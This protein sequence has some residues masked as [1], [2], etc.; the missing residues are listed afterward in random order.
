MKPE[1]IELFDAYLDGVMSPDQ[2]KDMEQ[3]ILTEPGLKE[4]LELH[5]MMLA[6]IQ[7]NRRHEL[8][9]FIS[10]NVKIKP[11]PFF[12]SY[13]FYSAAAASVV[14]CIIGY[15]VLFK[16]LEQ[17]QTAQ[18]GP[19]KQQVEQS[20]KADSSSPVAAQSPSE[21]KSP[22]TNDPAVP[23]KAAEHKKGEKNLADNGGLKTND[24]S[25]DADQKMAT[26]MSSNPDNVTVATDQM[27]LDTFLSVD[28]RVYMRKPKQY[29]TR[30]DDTYAVITTNDKRN[31][32]VQYWKSP[33][34]Y[35]GYKLTKN[36][37]TLYGNY[38]ASKI[39]FQE[40]NN[41]L[42]MKYNN[43]YYRLSPG[44][45]FVSLA[46]ETDARI[47]ADLDAKSAN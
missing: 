27:V 47:I 33:V 43:A 18:N 41:I 6:A 38:D 14:F 45:N 3:R 11:A 16:K 9:T 44:D 25:K 36:S 2:R 32:E 5:R 34:N 31:L 8:K 37:L 28:R 10:K 13:A 46:R 7:E 35:N 17:N 39:S 21:D 15:F 12:K 19:S 29:Q 1:N 24:V 20:Y 42:F 26:D 23:D 30:P 22:V 4:E 40:L